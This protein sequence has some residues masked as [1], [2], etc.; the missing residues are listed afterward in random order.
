[1]ATY[2]NTNLYNERIDGVREL[3]L[4]DFSA[5]AL[6]EVIVTH[7]DFIGKNGLIMFYAPWCPHCKKR[8]T[9]QLWS[10][11]A[12]S[13]GS[14]VPIG[15]VNCE[16][17]GNKTLA[18]YAQILGYPTIKYVHIDGT[19]E[20]YEGARTQKDI[21]NYICMKSKHCSFK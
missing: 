8:E 14:V 4:K 21:L 1:M 16:N 17:R 9:T 2:N 10:N 19:M 7:S 5:N 20:T 13:T 11:L 15:A 18:K 6:G 12:L 3:T